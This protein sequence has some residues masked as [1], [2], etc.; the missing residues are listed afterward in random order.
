MI[1]SLE[2][3]PAR[4]QIPEVEIRSFEP[5]EAERFYEVLVETFAE[6]WGAGFPPFEEWWRDIRG[7][8]EYNPDLSLVALK[9]GEMVGVLFGNMHG[10]LGEIHDIGVLREHRG[11]RIGE[12]LMYE[13]IE[14]FRE[15]GGKR[16]RLWVDTANVTGAIR[17]YERIGMKIA[18]RMHFYAKELV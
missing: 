14:R 16:L 18:R 2:K 13:I 12:A 5:A 3:P 17:L 6:H 10:E 7:L 11:R 9:D 1:M 8:E 4:A 15:Q